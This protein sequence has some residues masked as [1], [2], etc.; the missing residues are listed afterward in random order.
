[1]PYFK[2]TGVALDGRVLRGVLRARSLRD[3][4]TQLLHKDIGLMNAR[5]KKQ[6][7]TQRITIAIKIN[8]FRQLAI[9]VGSGVYIDRAIGLLALQTA[10]SSFREL[11]EDISI[12]VQHGTPIASA[13][14]SA[15]IFDYVSIQMIKAGHES[16]KL[17]QALE[18]I[19]AYA[20][21]R[22]AFYKKLRSAALVPLITFGTFILI[23]IFIMIGIVPTISSLFMSAG[24]ELPQITRIMIAISSML[25]SFG[26]ALIFCSFIFFV[27]ILRYLIRRIP[28]SSK[29]I[30]Y[31]PFI[32]PLV[33]QNNAASYLYAVGLLVSGKVR[34]AYALEIARSAVKNRWI[35]HELMSVEKNVNHGKSLSQALED[36][37]LFS[38][39]ICGLV[40]VGEQSSNLGLLLIKGAELYQE[41]VNRQLSL[42]TALFQPVL[43]M[44]LAFLVLALIVAIYI[45]LFDLSMIIS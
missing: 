3:L 45:P 7:F 5:F 35:A 18:M 41:K 16:G 2:W 10:H 39:E 33:R 17:G 23:V 11:L 8:F 22:D 15:G 26:G 21:S 43:M 25:T 24:H 20:E 37:G 9:L 36:C 6:S 34:I 40:S 44:V 12:E 29:I 31:I 28:Q 1:M 13:L 42:I 14:E 38:P 27:L 4:D 32:G 19:A 30:F